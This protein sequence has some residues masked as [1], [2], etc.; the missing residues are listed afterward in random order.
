M[1]TK[2]KIPTQKTQH[3][4]KEAA[5]KVNKDKAEAAAAS[6]F[7]LRLQQS[8]TVANTQVMPTTKTK[9]ISDDEQLAIVIDLSN[10][11]QN[12]TTNAQVVPSV[13]ATQVVPTINTI[14]SSRKT[15]DLSKLPKAREKIRLEPIAAATSVSEQIRIEQQIASRN[16]KRAEQQIAPIAAAT[17]VSEQIRIEQQIASRNK[18]RAKQQ[19]A[20]IAAATSV[21]EQIRIEQQIA[22]RN[23]KTELKRMNSFETENVHDRTA[24]KEKEARTQLVCTCFIY[25]SALKKNSRVAKFAI[26]TL[27]VIASCSLVLR[28][29]PYISLMK[30]PLSHYP[31][32]GSYS[33][34][35]YEP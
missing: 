26:G 20:P 6:Q 17:S 12:N 19:I 28:M 32:T 22:S 29:S 21:S 13:Y 2:T 18:K 3:F 9:L 35:V 14:S 30:I 8:N 5:L 10:A 11:Q 23:K 16:K 15:I 31:R 34:H 1:H 7:L 25:A 27:R 33:C 4:Q 24:R